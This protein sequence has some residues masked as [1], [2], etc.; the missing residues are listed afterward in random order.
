MLDN[1]YGVL[2]LDTDMTISGTLLAPVIEGSLEVSDGRLELDEIV[3]QVA[4]TNYATRAEYQGIPTARLRGAI[5]PDLLG[6]EDSAPELVRRHEHLHGRHGA[7]RQRRASTP[8]TARVHRHPRRWAIR[9]RERRRLRPVTPR[10]TPPR[11]HPTRLPATATAAATPA[12][13][14]GCLR[15][16]GA[17]H[18][19]ADPGQSD[20]PRPEHRGGARVGRRPERDAGWRFP[21]RQDGRQAGG[22]ARHRQHRPGRLLVPG[23]PLRPGA[24]RPDPLPRRRGDRSAPGHHRAAPHP[25]RRGTRAHPGDRPQADAVV[26][27][28]PAPRRGR[29]PRAHRLQPAD[30]PAR[31]GA[32]ELARREGRRHG[33]GVRR[34]AAGRGPREHAGPRPVRGG[35]HRSDR[36]RQPG[37]GHRAAGHPGHVPAV[38]PAVRQPA[39]LAVPARVPARRLPPA[40]GQR[41]RGRRTDGGQQVA[42]AAHRALRHGPG[43]LLL[44]SDAG[45]DANCRVPTGP[46]ASASRARVDPSRPVR[47]EGNGTRRGHG[48]VS[49]LPREIDE[50]PSTCCCCA[51]PAP[52]PT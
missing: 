5:V 18:P 14:A 26:V 24:R 16:D 13:E 7:G 20:R 45:Y 10:R 44:R 17:E 12:S 28:E 49:C 34:L 43:L 15:A 22:P 9:H 39:G 19:G 50:W 30:Q 41:R 37:G 48:P 27:L 2:D 3:P 23:T 47:L 52:I 4:N 11:R 33:R 51:T 32:A 8:A 42:H 29:H 35:D 46:T 21:R 36:P 6:A 1:E 38:P 25:G 31:D 40:A